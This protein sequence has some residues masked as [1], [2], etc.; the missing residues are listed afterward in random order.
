[1]KEVKPM[2]IA[3]IIPTNLKFAPYVQYYTKI[4]DEKQIEYKIVLWDKRNIK[5]EADSVFH[6]H[7]SDFDRKRT[8]LGYLL[9]D[10]HCK[11][12]LGKEQFDKI[13]FFTMAPLFFMGQR[14]LKRYK[15]K[16]ILDIRD[17][18]PF[19]RRFE[20]RFDEICRNAERVIVS[21]PRFAEWVQRETTICHNVDMEMLMK[22]SDIDPVT[23]FVFPIV[24]T[25]AGMMIEQNINIQV[26][27]QLGN[28][29]DFYFRFVGRPNR[30]MDEVEKYAKD[31]KIEN[32]SFEGEYK[33]EDIID[34]YRNG[35]TLI[36]IIRENTT[37]NKNA[38]PNKLYDAILAG[39]PLVVFDHNEAIA[40]YVQQ[41]N[42]GI[43]IRQDQM[44]DLETAIK[45]GIKGFDYTQYQQGRQS[46][47]SSVTNDMSVF[48]DV[49][50]RFV[51]NA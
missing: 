5:E 3:L 47:L 49:V 12:Y 6:F 17:D 42:L 22:Y 11:K 9:F 13:I 27:E 48:K 14:Y 40:S 1:M 37:I 39:I 34:I 4:L 24:I 38:L 10:K 41:F 50:H 7:T 2:K 44:N 16:Y 43:V 45:N 20:K 31:N 32:V 46:F 29:P 33:K 15:R 36:N 25:F 19:R 18:S 8:F 23:G 21:S 51:N 26:L 35:S 30:G 28:N